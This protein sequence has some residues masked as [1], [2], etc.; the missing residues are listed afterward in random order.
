MRSL[1]RLVNSVL[2]SLGFR[3]IPISREPH[4]SS[5][6]SPNTFDNF[7]SLAIAY[8]QLHN[9]NHGSGAIPADD[10]RPLL[11]SR[12]QGTRPGE[13]YHIIECLSLTKS[14]RG[15]VCEFGVAQG[16][17]SALIANEIRDTDKVL[18]LFDSFQ[19]LSKPTGKDQLRDDIFSLGSIEA[20]EG[21]MAYPQKAV[22]SSLAAL[23]FPEDRLVIHPGFIETT[24]STDAQ[25]P[26][27]ISLAYIDFDLYQP[28]TTALRF[29]AEALLPGGVII[30][31]DY[32]HFSTGAKI[33]VDEFFSEQNVRGET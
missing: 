19:G 29:V 23:Q 5:E 14:I 28:I 33:A 24:I 16:E 13:A 32:D 20:Y 17:T 4:E 15:D 18:H 2:G 21:S 12:L 3:I 30:V 8:E 25:L 10:L 11:L 31:D 26:N 7:T 1:N 22:L 27:H 6:M 9:E